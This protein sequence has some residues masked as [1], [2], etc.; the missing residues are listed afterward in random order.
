MRPIRPPALKKGDVIGVCAPASPP[1]RDG[2]LQKG[3]AY[4]ERLGYR[5]EPGRSLHK[6]DGYL[7]GSDTA[8][9]ADLN[10]FFR[11]RRIRAIVSIRGGYGSMRIL[12]LID[13][14]AAR[15]D[16]KIF[17]GYSD[18]TALQLALFARCGLVTFAGPMVAAGMARGLKA[19]EEELFWR[20]LTSRRPIGKLATPSKALFPGT[21]SGIL[22]GGNLSILSRLAG[23][24]YLP[25]LRN[26]ILLFEEVGERPYRVDRML[27]QLRLAGALSGA[28]GVVLGQFTDCRPEEGKPSL[29]LTRIF[30]DTFGG[31]RAPVL[32][33]VRHGHVSGSLTLPI[34]LRVEM[35]AGKK[36]AITFP[37]SA[38][39]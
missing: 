33:G 28:R 1:L 38:V 31:L 22:L 21:A 13:Y 9:A 7:A 5:V 23:T 39:V 16:P 35:H 27:Q 26:R 19:A 17:V 4:L 24:P 6:K 18:L 29:S 2:D 14:R 37:G 3:I 11:D 15:N 25:S 30:R 36:C 12:D 32:T 34:G 10:G 20:M 8:R